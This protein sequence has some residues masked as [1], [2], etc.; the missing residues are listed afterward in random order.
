MSA[1]AK[2]PVATGVIS[3]LLGFPSSQATPVQQTEL[4]K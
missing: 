3:T 2:I 1:L 4:G